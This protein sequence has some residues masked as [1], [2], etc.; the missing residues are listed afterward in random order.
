MFT[1]FLFLLIDYVIIFFNLRLSFCLKVLFFLFLLCS[2]ILGEIYSFYTIFPFWDNVLHFVSGS[3][4]TYASFLLF[5]KFIKIVNF[6][7]ILMCIVFSFSCSLSFGVLWEFVEFSFDKYLESDM[8][9]DAILTSF[10]TTYFSSVY[11]INHVGSI[12]KTKIY[13]NNS[14]I[15][16]DNGY[17]DIGL[18]D[19]MID[20]IIDSLGA[21]FASLIMGYCLTKKT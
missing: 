5:N 7:T 16:I 17:L 15:S 20:L 9:K 21:L 14:V 2:E 4:V 11:N 10:N 3:I 12:T 19:T 8:Q 18:Y 6:S 1:L 13:T